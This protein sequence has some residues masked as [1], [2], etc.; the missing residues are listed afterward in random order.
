MG[1]VKE[2][3]GLGGVD[4]ARGAEQG[5]ELVAPQR[6]LLWQEVEDAAAVVVDDDDSD[7]GLDLAQGGEAADVVE[8]AEVAGDDRRRP[9]AGLGGADP[10]GGEAV[11]P[12]GAAVAE[13][14]DV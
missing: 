2:R 3:G 11:D 6:R 9:A 8:E 12:V 7:R 1:Q 14:V 13:E 5:F 4:A 10:G